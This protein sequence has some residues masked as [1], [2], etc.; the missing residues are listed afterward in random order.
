MKKLKRRRLFALILCFALLLPSGTLFVHA[1][2]PGMVTGNGVR[3]RSGPSSNDTVLFSLIAG[4]IVTISCDA[5]NG[6]YPVA[7]LYNGSWYN[8]YM[9]ADYVQP[10]QSSQPGPVN[11]DFN[12]QLASFPESYRPY[13]TAIHNA[14][15]AWKFEAVYTNLDWNYVQQ[16]E[17]LTGRSLIQ[18]D[19]SAFRAD[20][21]VREG[22]DW[23]QAHPGVVAYYM[24]PR[25]FLN[26][27][28]IFQFEKLSYEGSDAVRRDERLG[29]P[30]CVAFRDFGGDGRARHGN[31]QKQDS[32][33]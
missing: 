13:L 3:F 19:N 14:H 1:D 24:D 7:A 21:V 20:N 2:T 32:D 16:Q 31:C 9:Y 29:R 12:V 18:T 28:D 8:G 11:G 10:V 27:N 23:Y 5:V 26:E 4:D 15:P 30:R 6:W 25:N 17:N 22:R 33:P